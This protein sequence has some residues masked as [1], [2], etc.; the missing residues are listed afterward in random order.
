M[1]KRTFKM[2]MWK[3]NLGMGVGAAIFAFAMLYLMSLLPL[4]FTA[5]GSA[6]AAC[7]LFGCIFGPALFAAPFLVMIGGMY[8]FA[9]KM[10]IS[11]M[12][13]VCG[14]AIVYYALLCALLILVPRWDK[15]VVNT[16]D[17][18][19]DFQTQHQGEDREES[20]RRAES[21]AEATRPIWEWLARSEE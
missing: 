1:S 7:V 16:R 18:Y 13:S 2:R 15:V 8:V 3:I 6:A 9:V 12:L 20:Y 5:K 11:D 21:L 4:Q 19:H 10:R 14:G 17:G